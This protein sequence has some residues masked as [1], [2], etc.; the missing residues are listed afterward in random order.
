MRQ[1]EAPVLDIESGPEPLARLLSG[2]TRRHLETV[3]LPGWL[4]AR[5]WYAAKNADT[6]EVSILDVTPFDDDGRTALAVLTATPPN[7]PAQTYFLPVALRTEAAEEAT[8]AEVRLGEERLRLADALVDEAVVRELARRMLAGDGA[9]DEKTGLVFRGSSAR[10]SGDPLAGPVKRSGAE[11]SNTSLRIGGAMLK[12]IRKLEI[13]IHPELEMTRHLTE[14]AA[15]RNAPALLGSLERVDAEGQPTALC[16]LQALVPNEGDGWSYTLD[17]LGRPQ[18]T[19]ELHR[20]AECLGTRTAELHRALAE[21]SDD[22]DFA[23]EPLDAAR[24]TEWADGARQQARLALDALRQAGPRLGA[25]REPAARLQARAEELEARISEWTPRE[26]TAART[27]LHGDYHL[28]QVLVG[29]DDVFIIDFEGEP[30]RPL[31]ER[32][33]KHS[34]LKDVAGMLR[35]FAYAGAAGAAAADGE[36]AETARR[37]AA[38]MGER[39]LARYREI[40]GDCASWP[41][42]PDDADR[43]LRLFLLEKALY[44]V[45]YEVANRPDWLSTPLMGVLALLD[46]PTAEAAAVPPLA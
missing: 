34:P 4:K 21:R 43:L 7:Q 14:R 39:F 13:G 30:M 16:V 31:A 17:R 15:F 28:G 23:P 46:A 18:A 1:D 22:P 42:D 12:A 29:Q 6:P 9:C 27:R 44:E 20:L 32:R 33:A 5:R 11:Q 10:Q 41:D 40:I 19:G 26:V 45:R 3:I 24:L 25:A 37:T 38:E 8:M 2:A 35:S 36:G